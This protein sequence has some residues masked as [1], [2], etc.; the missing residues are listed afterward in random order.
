M[1]SPTSR[2][3][4][5]GSKTR[6]DERKTYLVDWWYWL[7]FAIRL[8]CPTNSILE[9]KKYCTYNSNSLKRYNVVQLVRKLFKLEELST[10]RQE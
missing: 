1:V 2:Q 5:T 9:D 7:T 4:I 8:G 6:K 10:V 3:S